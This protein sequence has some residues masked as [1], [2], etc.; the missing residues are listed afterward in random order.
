MLKIT[1]IIVTMETIFGKYA[2]RRAK[3]D[4]HISNLDQ[5]YKLARDT[6]YVFHARRHR[7]TSVL[8]G[9]TADNWNMALYSK[10]ER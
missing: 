2:T 5:E 3:N 9:P 10:G 7:R 4:K 6:T 8:S 1:Y